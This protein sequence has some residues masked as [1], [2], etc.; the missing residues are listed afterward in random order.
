MK[1]ERIT[2]SRIIDICKDINSKKYTTFCAISD[3]HKLGKFFPKVF[4]DSGLI[5]KEDGYYKAM[6]RISDDRFNLFNSKKRSYYK[7]WN[8]QQPTMKSKAKKVVKP[9]LKKF[10]FI[11]RFKILLTGKA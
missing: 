2:K 9:T 1:K 6:Q 4:L 8:Q 5:W 3:Y 11:Q 7:L 10:G